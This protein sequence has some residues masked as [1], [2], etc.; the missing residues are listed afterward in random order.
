MEAPWN[1]ISGEEASRSG[2]RGVLNPSLSDRPILP[3][4]R[5]YRSQGEIRIV[6]QVTA[7]L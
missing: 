3:V 4:S 5:P 6:M 1:Q 7:R 2:S